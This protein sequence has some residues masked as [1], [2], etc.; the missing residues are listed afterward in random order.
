MQ[1]QALSTAVNPTGAEIF[2]RD[3]ALQLAGNLNALPENPP[4]Y[5]PSDA[6]ISGLRLQENAGKSGFNK[7]N[8]KWYSHASVEGGTNT[9]AYGHK[10]TK[11]EAAKGIYSKGITEEQANELLKKDLEHHL[12]NAKK[13]F[14]SKYGENA[15]DK[16]PN[17]LKDVLVDYSYNGVLNK[18]NN[19][20]QGVYNY[21]TAATPEQKELAH[22]QMLKEYQRKAGDKLLTGRN[23]WTKGMLESVPTRK[24]G[25]LKFDKGGPKD[26]GWREYKT[27]TGQSIY[28]DPNFKSYAR[29]L[30][31]NG[32]IIPVTELQKFSMIYDPQA[33]AWD[34]T[35]SE[36]T[37]NVY[38]RRMSF[39]D[40][41]NR[42]LGDPMG[43]AERAS[44][45][46]LAPGEDPTD[47]F[48]HPLAGMYTQQAIANK[49]GNIPIVSP[50]LG[51]LG[52]NAMGVGH[53]LGTIFNDNRPLKY[54]GREALEDIFNNAYGATIG[55][56]PIPN[57]SKE[58]ILYKTSAKNMIPDGISDLDGRDFYFKKMGGKKC[59]TCNSSKMKVL[60]NKAN[61][62]K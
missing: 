12:N 23:T 6:C 4:A 14:N 2:A 20:T 54:K 29:Y 39:E 19:F 38:D 17:E 60:Y 7:N 55:L 35:H 5:Y 43:K 21:S 30:D 25:G 58:E 45:Q 1:A 8:N 40:R 42:S 34:S 57:K 3:N 31:S 26:K 32:N 22:Q 51:W 49:T 61:Y 15:F 27:P 37:L 41:L 44:E 9:I 24:Y 36:K 47:N 56:L 33:N 59:Y 46:D 11:E 48:R 52:A 13:V 16:V 53:E 62:K 10:L 28:L 50:A 18:F